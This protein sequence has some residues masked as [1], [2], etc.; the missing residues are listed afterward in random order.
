MI[1]ILFKIKLM[2]QKPFNKN[3]IT[4]IL[5][6]NHLNKIQLKKILKKKLK[7]IKINNK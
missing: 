1:K 7:I 2:K 5:K 6:N 4:K 3:K